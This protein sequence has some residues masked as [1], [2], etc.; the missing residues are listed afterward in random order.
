MLN[1]KLLENKILKNSGGDK[2]IIDYFIL[3]LVF[4]LCYVNGSTLINIFYRKM[5]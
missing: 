1:V 5:V 3:I 4:K 2:F